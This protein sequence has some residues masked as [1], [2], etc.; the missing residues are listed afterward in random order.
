MRS[1]SSP[2]GSAAAFVMARSPARIAPEWIGPEWI[3]PEWIGPEWIRPEWIGTAGV[4][5]MNEQSPVTERVLLRRDIDGIAWLTM[6]R[7]QARNAL[8]IALMTA[9]D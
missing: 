6:N 9:L 2:R 7:P 4:R 1:D 3:G 5:T 8:S